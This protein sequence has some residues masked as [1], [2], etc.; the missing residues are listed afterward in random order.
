MEKN[1]FIETL[2]FA[3]NDMLPGVLSDLAPDWSATSVVDGWI[4]DK[5]GEEVFL[6]ITG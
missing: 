3:I 2:L 5:D 1:N 4:F 6:S